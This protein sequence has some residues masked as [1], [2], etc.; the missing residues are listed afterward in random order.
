MTIR[1]CEAPAGA[2]AAAAAQ[3]LRGR[4]LTRRRVDEPDATSQTSKPGRVQEAAASR[5]PRGCQARLVRLPLPALE[6]SQTIQEAPSAAAP[7]LP[8]PSAARPLP[9]ARCHKHTPCAHPT[10]SVA[11]LLGRQAKDEGLRCSSWCSTNEGCSGGGA[12]P[13]AWPK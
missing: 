4:G 9:Q 5:W 7:P 6:P 3:R 10:A 12:G 8:P 11:P 1:R 13:G 2:S